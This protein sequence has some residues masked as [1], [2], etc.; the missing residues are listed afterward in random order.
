MYATTTLYT[1][2]LLPG[3]TKLI[4][5]ILHLLSVKVCIFNSKVKSILF[6]RCETWLTRAIVSQLQ[7][8]I[9]RCLRKPTPSAM[10]TCGGTSRC[11]NQKATVGMVRPYPQK[12]H[13]THHK[14]CPR[15]EPTRN[16]QRGRP[17]IT[18]KRTLLEEGSQV[19]PIL[20]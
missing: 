17:E 18:W 15:L 9:N 6:Y 16:P 3:S 20:R 7:E 10:R 4:I 12:T 8:F 1:Q 13:S 14:I 11:R 2:S 19:G 5:V